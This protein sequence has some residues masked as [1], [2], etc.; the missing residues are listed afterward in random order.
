MTSDKAHL[1]PDIF[2]S[3]LQSG[4]FWMHHVSAKSGYFFI[5]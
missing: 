1:Y 5:H 2:E 4:N 3:A